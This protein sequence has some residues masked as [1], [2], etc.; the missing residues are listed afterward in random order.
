M[1]IELNQLFI[2]SSTEKE[3]TQFKNFSS[4][5]P[6]IMKPFYDINTVKS[7]L[8]QAT[9]ILNNEPNLVRIEFKNQTTPYQNVIN[10]NN[11]NYLYKECEPLVFENNTTSQLLETGFIKEAH[12]QMLEQIKIIEDKMKTQL[13]Q[14]Y[15]VPKPSEEMKTII[16]SDLHGSIDSL[17]DVFNTYGFGENV[18]YVFLGDYSDRGPFGIE[19]IVYLCKL[20]IMNPQQFIMLRGNHEDHNEFTFF[21]TQ[22]ELKAKYG[23]ELKIE[24][25]YEFFKAL[26]LFCSV[27]GVL[28]GHSCFF[29]SLAQIFS[30]NRKV[31]N[32]KKDPDMYQML[33][34]LFNEVHG[35]ADE[36]F[37]QHENVF[38][39]FVRGHDFK[40]NG[41]EIVGKVVT[42]FGIKGYGTINQSDVIEVFEK[43]WFVRRM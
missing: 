7:V 9:P 28:C 33:W 18:K 34:P 13:N 19:I 31:L 42:I 1:D 8:A 11:V 2:H 38:K 10:S 43:D 32:V 6:K 22:K 25:L 16:V 39:L 20:K 37:S 4:F 23:D 15:E 17:Y 30:L 40:R 36:F 35:R 26:P 41:I 29:T 24:D 5:N 21:A 27:N 3:F 14:E 12:Q